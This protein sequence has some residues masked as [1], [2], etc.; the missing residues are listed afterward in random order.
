[1]SQPTVLDW[2]AAELQARLAPLLPGIAV[3]VLAESGSTNTLLIE[4]ARV[5]ARP[6]LLVS[7]HQTGGR[8]RMGRTWVA[9]PGASLTFSLGL[10]LPPADWSGLSLAVG[11]CI[12]DALEPNGQSL[13]IKWPND[14]WLVD[15][16]RTGRKLGGVLIESQLR[17]EERYLV[18]GVGL[19][20]RA[21]TTADAS[22]FG[23][24]YAALEELQAGLDAPTV[25]ARVAP[26]L[27]QCVLEF[28]MGGF[29]AWQDRFDKRDLCKGR[30]VTAGELRGIAQGV[31]NG[32]ELLL[33]TPSGMHRI[34]SGEV[35]LRLDQ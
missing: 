29:A 19:N 23:S 13:R 6:T 3:E 8:G 28:G 17:G 25:L 27:L 4:R 12:A 32:G 35:S 26:A 9:E 2:R 20:V 15:A 24:G 21:T 10:P 7:E 11:C 34:A 5:E 14:L 30:P 22:Q 33:Q 16:Q 1:M 18:V 31:S